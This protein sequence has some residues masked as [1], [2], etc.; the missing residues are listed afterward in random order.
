MEVD[1][2]TTNNLKC[3]NCGK[4]GHGSRECKEPAKCYNCNK[5]G[6][7][8]RNCKEP[9]QQKDKKG[10]RPTYTREL[11]VDGL[12][13]DMGTEMKEKMAQQLREES[14]GNSQ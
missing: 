8:S 2:K 14:F 1:K 12:M 3:Y 5:S 6:H 4:L 10:K 9:Q 7:I 13:M 11:T